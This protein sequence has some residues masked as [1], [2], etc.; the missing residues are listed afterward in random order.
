MNPFASN[1]HAAA[2]RHLARRDPV[3]RALIRHVGDCRL[4]AGRWPGAFE[5]LA[6]A[7]A[8]QQLHGRAANAILERF[9]ALVP[10]RHFPR[11]ADVLAL[12]PEAL[13][14]VG[15]SR[16]K[17]AALR[18]LADKAEAGLLPANRALA[19]MDDEAIIDCF[20]QVRGVGRWTVQMLLMFQLGRPD[21]M[22]VDD[23]GL[24][25]G[26]RLAYGMEDMP[27]PRELLAAAEPWRPHRSV[28]SWYLW[29]AAEAGR[30]GAGNVM[31]GAAAAG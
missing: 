8:H 5:A 12:D 30:Q 29:R 18:D 31:T 23:F 13:R 17:V 14:G 19:G 28:A 25:S 7:I 26:Y 22:A 15:F 27:S 1:P 21:V 10:G 24:R 6:S 20:V 4:A 16:A 3:M 11:P 9:K 2:Q